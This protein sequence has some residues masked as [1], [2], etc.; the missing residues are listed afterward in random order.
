VETLYAV[1]LCLCAE[2]STDPRRAGCQPAAARWEK[3]SLAGEIRSRLEHNREG[4]PR[5]PESGP[6][7][8][9]KSL[10]AADSA[11]H[12]AELVRRCAAGDSHAFHELTERYYRPVC[13]FLFKRLQQPDL[14]EDLAQETFLEAYR[15]IKQGRIPDR[16]SSWLFG[17]AVNRCGKWFRKKKPAL[18]GDDPPDVLATPFHSP[19]EELEEQQKQLQTLDGA[20]AGLPDDI[21]KLLDLK[22]R[23]G[24][25]CEQ[26]AA[27]LGQP[28]G[29][30]KSQLSRTY[31]LLR[32]RMSEPE[33]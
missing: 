9:P 20:L 25:T 16:F 21:R 22:H 14:V 17:I 33:A 28:V 32:T 15:S 13:G 1:S 24:K 19:Q 10:P 8:Q 11:Q 3:P 4:S 27:E 31:K 12:D 26:I 23:Q 7:M 2:I 5:A 29:T 6:T 30:I 18:F